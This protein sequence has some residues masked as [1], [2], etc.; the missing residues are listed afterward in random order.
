MIATTL[1]HPIRVHRY[2]GGSGNAKY[3]TVRA[4]I[5]AKYDILLQAGMLRMFLQF[6]RSCDRI[7]K[8]AR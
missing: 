7:C 8:L 2:R 6:G 3:S 1:E 4:H 5:S